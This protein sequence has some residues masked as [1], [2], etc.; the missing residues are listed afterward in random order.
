MRRTTPDDI[1]QP[2]PRTPNTPQGIATVTRMLAPALLMLALISVSAEAAK[3]YKWVDKD[4]V[5]HYSAQP[6]A[7]TPAET[8]NLRTGQSSK[9]DAPGHNA[10]APGEAA[11]PAADPK[12]QG[13]Q[14]AEADDAAKAR[15]KAEDEKNQARCDKALKTQRELADKPRVKVWDETSNAYRVLPD[16]ELRAWRDEVAREVRQYCD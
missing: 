3:F 8:L 11:T 12:A 6:P 4:G 13:K 15:A 16:E 14:A 7:G 10:S 2:M 5:T 1:R 9:D